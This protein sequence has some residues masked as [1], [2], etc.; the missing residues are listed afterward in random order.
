MDP[1]GNE[2]TLAFVASWLR[3]SSS[4]AQAFREQQDKIMAS[5]DYKAGSRTKYK[6]GDTFCNFATYATNKD[7]APGLNKAMFDKGD[8]TGDWTC[9]N[10]AAKNLA[11]AAADP[12]SSIKEVTPKQAQALANRGYAVV[13]EHITE[14]HG[15]L[16]TVRVGGKFS[17]EHGPVINNIGAASRTGS[18]VLADKAFVG[19]APVHYYYDSNQFIKSNNDKMNK[20]MEKY[21]EHH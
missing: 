8:T 1:D 4:Q 14:P 5:P 10:H 6:A 18:D 11:M 17:K 13:G 9:A 2:S 21:Y 7:F 12:N 16:A 3:G 19:D 20:L 15:H